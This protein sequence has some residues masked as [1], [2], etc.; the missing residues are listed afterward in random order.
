MGFAEDES[1]W[2]EFLEQWPLERLRKMSLE[3]YTSAGDTNSFTYWLEFKLGD[4]GSIAGG[5]SFKFAIFS[6]KDVTQKTGDT[7]L[8]YDSDYGWY[9]RFGATPQAAFEAIRGHIINVVE[10]AQAGRL[11]DIDGSPLGAMYRWKIA[12]HYQSSTNQ[13]IPCIYTRR[14]LLHALNLPLTDRSTPQSSLYRGLANQRQ[15]RESIVAFSERIWRTWIA[16]S[17]CVVKLTEGAIK[18]GYL[19]V[20]LVSAPFPETMYGG[21]TEENMGEAAAFRTDT[22]ETFSS[23]IRKS[24]DGSGRLR[25]RLGSYFAAIGA[26]AGDYITITQAHDGT[27]S[28]VRGAGK[29][30]SANETGSDPLPSRVEQ[31]QKA[32]DRRTMPPLNQI[33]FGP[34]GTGKTY[35]S[36]EKALQILDP[37]FVAI[38]DDEDED[39][40]GVRTKLKARFDELAR[41]GLIQFITFHQSFSYEDFVEGIRAE[42][43]EDDGQLRYRVAD[44][45]FKRLCN[46]A[47]TRV[48]DGKRQSFDPKGR[49]IWKL[50]LG[51][52]VDNR[53]IYEECIEKGVALIGYGAK[54]DFSRCQSREDIQ[55]VFA[56]AGENQDS[57][58][59]PVSAINAFVRQM[60]VGDLVVATEGNLKFRAIGEVTGDYRTV[61]REDDTYAQ[62]RNVRWLRVYEPALP[63]DS[64]MENRFMQKT[65]YELRPGSLNLGKFTALLKS[66]DEVVGVGRPRVLIIDEINRGNV[67][68]IFGEL[69]TL[70]EPSKRAGAPE[71]LEVILPYSKERFSVPDN[72]YLIGTMN[73]ADRS[74]AGLDIALRRRFSFVE[75][76]PEPD[77]LAGVNVGGVDLAA[78]LEIMNRRIEV[79]LDRDHQVGHAYF[80]SLRN[81]DGLESLARV[82]R[83]QVVPLLQEYFFEDWRRIA[84]VLNDHRKA[85]GFRFV[86]P[87]AYGVE[88]LFGSSA[89]VPTDVRLWRLDA[90]A[91][92]REQSYLGIIEAG[93]A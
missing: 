75:M 26:K 71:S 69:I 2:S 49:R 62:C 30:D 15:S 41:D 9:R 76:P 1:L 22:G 74:L 70:L 56:G 32:G 46:A 8:A 31:Q 13:L 82:F 57:G 67:S 61:P 37:K 80:M 34:P 78:L 14:P 39:D 20:N 73:T 52:A 25:R 5:S 90:E 54:A 7:S 77:L 93:V 59:Y 66:G 72:V 65:I 88:S 43:D 63:Y 24:S 45:I 17:P 16:S 3:E 21:K 36:I 85:P 86:V 23:D 44:G 29:E 79:L 33:L 84:W 18:N 91:F 12:F 83:E 89:E 55:R 38:L 50:S 27:Y 42:V 58:S 87:P 60:K 51:G 92:T 35:L 19:T 4:F 47:R 53:E 81:G 64:L 10:A 40:I 28:L 68:R 6:R 48:V 11:E